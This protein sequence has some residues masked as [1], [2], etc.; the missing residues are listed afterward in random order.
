M[1]QHGDHCHPTGRGDVHDHARDAGHTHGADHHHGPASFG[2]AFAVGIALNSGFVVGEWIA[3]LHADSLALMADAAHNLGDVLSLVLAWVAM[4]LSARLPSA[5]FTYGLRGSSILAALVNACVLLLVTGALSWEAI[6]R[7]SDPQ[8][9]RGGWVV[10]TALVGVIINGAT[11]WLFTSGRANDLNVRAA[12]LHMAS[13][14]VVSF[15]VVVAG[16]AVL[17]TAW[18][19][20]DPLLTLAVSVVIVWQTA[21][22]LIESLRLALQA[23]PRN[24]DSAAV[25]RFLCELPGVTEV[26]DLHIWAMSTTENALTAHL[27]IPGRHPGDTFLQSTSELLMRR[28]GIQHPTLQIEVADTRSSCAL[29][30]DHIV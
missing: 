18:Y 13:D 17:Y 11:A 3:G 28:F 19:W 16:V 2:R 27:V 15:A 9:L 14:A 10:A 7:L 12:Y 25:K 26:H 24:I 20:L 21:R 1:A 6:L 22:L 8:P 23:V 29:A 4:R 30:P 5:R